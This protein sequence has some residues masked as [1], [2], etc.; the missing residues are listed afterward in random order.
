MVLIKPVPLGPKRGVAFFLPAAALSCVLFASQSLDGFH[1]LGV[2]LSLAPL[3]VVALLWVRA[4][5]ATDASKGR[6]F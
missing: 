3:Q 5:E 6:R 2:L 1:P 4:S